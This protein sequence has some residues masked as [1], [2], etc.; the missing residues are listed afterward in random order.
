[1]DRA[2]RGYADQ[3][4]PFIWCDDHHIR[5]TSFAHLQSDLGTFTIVTLSHSVD[6]DSQNYMDPIA[7]TQH[8]V[9]H[10]EQVL[11]LL[12]GDCFGSR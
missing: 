3:T 4:K 9:A 1:M 6:F 2:L 12:R 7:R 5:H 11:H 8:Q 10:H